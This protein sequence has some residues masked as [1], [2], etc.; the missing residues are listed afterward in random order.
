MHSPLFRR[1]RASRIPFRRNFDVNVKC[2]RVKQVA[3]T[4][5]DVPWLAVKC[6]EHCRI[7][8]KSAVKVPWRCS[9]SFAFRFWWKRYLSTTKNMARATTTSFNADKAPLLLMSPQLHRQPM[10][11]APTVPLLP[12]NS[13]RKQTTTVRWLLTLAPRAST[14]G[15]WCLMTRQGSNHRSR[16]KTMASYCSGSRWMVARTVGTDAGILE[17]RKTSNNQHVSCDRCKSYEVKRKLQTVSCIGYWLNDCG[18]IDLQINE[19]KTTKIRQW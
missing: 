8:V 15:R 7:A 19:R 18:S 1:D 11:S 6:S 12:R 14:A 2:T 17:Q 5:S 16:S 10:L 13:H 3:V 9:E 4:C